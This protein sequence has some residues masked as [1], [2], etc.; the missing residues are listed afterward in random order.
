MTLEHRV[1]VVEQEL[2]I[3]KSQ[4]QTTLLTI[5]EHLLKNT[6]PALRTKDARVMQPAAEAAT[7][8]TQSSSVKRIS[9][10]EP[11]SES[12]LPENTSLPAPQVKQLQA[13][14]SD[15]NASRYTDSYQPPAPSAQRAYD[16]PFYREQNE[17]FFAPAARRGN[18]APSYREQSEQFS[19]P[20]MPSNHEVRYASERNRDAQERT[21]A[22]DLRLWIELDKWVDQKVK[23]VGIQ[24][25]RE[26][27]S[28]FDGPERELL[29]QVVEIYEKNTVVVRPNHA[30][31]RELSPTPEASQ[32]RTV[33]EEWQKFA[34]ASKVRNAAYRP[35]GEHQELA[36]RLIADI[37][38]AS[39]A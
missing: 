11:A 33:A 3:L 7:S 8:I 25:T 12:A 32:S 35:F 27:I 6:Y 1:L 18:D 5:Q 20:G 15:G 2:Q 38:G 24:R 37:L 31:A 26:L 30:P 16:E 13:A 39:Q 21:P 19:A 23:E 36:L 29:M 9:I 14:G 22:A 10:P 4:I 34:N 17:Q 28:L